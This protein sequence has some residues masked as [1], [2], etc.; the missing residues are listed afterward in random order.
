MDS[1]CRRR[2]MTFNLSWPVCWQA[3]AIK[4]DH[5]L[6]SGMHLASILLSPSWA[7]L[8]SLSRNFSPALNLQRTPHIPW[9][10]MECKP[11]HLPI[12]VPAMVRVQDGYFASLA[13]F[14][15]TLYHTVF[16]EH[17]AHNVTEEEWNRTYQEWHVWLLFE[18]WFQN[19]TGSCDG[20]RSLLY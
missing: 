16:P 15:T 12:W 19:G 9:T 5:S 6:E 8:R 18:R 10:A 7:V 17:K 20:L 2:W 14:S 1:S 11:S 4:L 13:L 3:T